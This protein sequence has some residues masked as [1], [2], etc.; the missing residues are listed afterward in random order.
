MYKRRENRTNTFFLII[1]LFVCY[2]IVGCTQATVDV[3]FT[4]IIKLTRIGKIQKFYFSIRKMKRVELGK[5]HVYSLVRLG[6]EWR[7][8]K[9]DSR[10]NI[11]VWFNRTFI[12]TGFFPCIVLILFGDFDASSFNSHT[13]T[14]IH[15]QTNKQFQINALI[16]YHRDDNRNFL[17][18]RSK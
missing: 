6:L 10:Q 11:K 8:F 5:F 15:T 14:R 7:V 12:F 1:L 17:Q 3:F 16:T 2:A 13:Q 18:K 9:D 4:I